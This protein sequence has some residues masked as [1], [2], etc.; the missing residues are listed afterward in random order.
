LDDSSSVISIRP[1][2]FRRQMRALQANGVSVVGLESLLETE[3]SQRPTLAL[4]FD[5]GFENFYAEAVPVLAER[6]FPATVFL[7]SG[8]CGRTNDW[9][10]QPARFGSLHLLRW[11]QVAE[12]SRAGVSFGAHTV[13]HPNLTRLPLRA[14]L[15][16]MLD[17]KRE[18]E[19]RTGLPV[20]AFAYPYGAESPELREAVASH[21]AVGCSTRL[22]LLTPRSPRE[23]LERIDVYYLR[24]RIWFEHLFHP[25]TAGYLAWRGFWRK[26]RSLPA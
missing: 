19:D 5:D 23:S 26:W 2:T 1:D 4:T 25:M 20:T 17:S 7:V 14:A 22:G 24:R 21:F 6:E 8:Y 11:S 12:L 10:S 13:N 15:G 3:K 16:E 9:P 18:I